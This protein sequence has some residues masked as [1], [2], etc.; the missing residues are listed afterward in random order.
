MYKQV[1]HPT[2]VLQV[3]AASVAAAVAVA[4]AVAAA[5]S[6]GSAAST[7][8]PILGGC[9]GLTNKALLDAYT[10]SPPWSVR[11]AVSHILRPSMDSTSASH[12]IVDSAGRGCG[13]LWVCQRAEQYRA[14]KRGAGGCKRYVQ[15]PAVVLN[16]QHSWH[17]N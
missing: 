13:L 9:L 3:C 4:P 8:V 12:T 5:G 16:P 2:A 11:R 14:A 10:V 17:V 1:T 15:P 7:A 6:T